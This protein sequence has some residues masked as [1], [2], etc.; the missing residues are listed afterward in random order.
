MILVAILASLAAGCGEAA[1]QSD[2]SYVTK[3]NEICASLAVEQRR[4]LRQ[5]GRRYF[6]EPKQLADGIEGY[7]DVIATRLERIKDLGRPKNPPRAYISSLRSY[8]RRLDNAPTADPISGLV[9]PGPVQ[10]LLEEQTPRMISEAR[11]YG[12]AACK[13]LDAK[14]LPGTMPGVDVTPSGDEPQ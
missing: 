7:R 12:I 1:P 10:R 13:D 6:G 14:P 3:A 11:S 4:A 5:L 9:D 8:V 2:K